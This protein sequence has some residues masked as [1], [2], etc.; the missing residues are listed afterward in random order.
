MATAP[1]HTQNVWSVLTVQPKIPGLG[2]KWNTRCFCLWSSCFPIP[3][4]LSCLCKGS[5]LPAT[6]ETDYFRITCRKIS[7]CSYISRDTVTMVLSVTFHSQKQKGITRPPHQVSKEAE[8]PQLGTMFHAL[9]LHKKFPCITATF[10]PAMPKLTLN[11]NLTSNGVSVFS[12]PWQMSWK[13]KYCVTK[14]Y[15]KHVQ[16]PLQLQNSRLFC[17]L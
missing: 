16:P 9:Q 1:T 4:S 8:W 13:Y 5:N 17:F 2:K 7:D 6:N 12:A 10:L 11:I 3:N 15:F 14:L